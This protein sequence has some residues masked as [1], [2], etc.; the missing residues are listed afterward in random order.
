MPQ[1]RLLPNIM[2]AYT[3]FFYSPL[4]LTLCE[5]VPIR[6]LLEDMD[7]YSGGRGV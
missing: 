3:A 2:N 1:S 5:P 6:C 4:L 7:G